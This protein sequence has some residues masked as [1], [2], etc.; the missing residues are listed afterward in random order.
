MG[1]IDCT[2]SILI[3]AKRERKQSRPMGKLQTMAHQAR[4]AQAEHGATATP[5]TDTH[6]SRR[7]IETIT[8]T[9]TETE[10]E[11]RIRG[12]ETRDGSGRNKRK[13]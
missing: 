4:S 1:Q 11:I 2:L 6:R 3:L 7:S 8:E 12:K 10:T 13:A 9:Q 5:P